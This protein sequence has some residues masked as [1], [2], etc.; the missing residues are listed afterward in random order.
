MHFEETVPRGVQEEV[1]ASAA[2]I[3]RSRAKARRLTERGTCAAMQG[4]Q[5]HWL[6]IQEQTGISAGGSRP[7]SFRPGTCAGAWV[8]TV[9]DQMFHT[10]R[11]KIGAAAFLAGALLIAPSASRADGDNGVVRVRS[12]YSMAETIGRL[13]AD[14]AGKGIMFFAEIDQAKLAKEAG[15]ELRPS[16]L[17]IFG[18]PPLGTQFLTSNPDAGLDW[19]VRVLVQQDAKGS[20]SVAYTDFNWIARRYGIEDRDA[21]FKMAS[22]VIGSIA[23]TVTPQ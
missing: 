18:N 2:P 22:Q 8:T 15:I 3:E 10:L 17:L 19:P 20:V 6:S 12:A 4:W 21:Q 13:K 14:I 11:M 23:T 9:E 5:H 16:T 7:P 1:I